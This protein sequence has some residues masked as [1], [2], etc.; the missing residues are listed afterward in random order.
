MDPLSALASAAELA[1]LATRGW[2]ALKASQPEYH[3]F[4]KSFEKELA[5]RHRD[6]PWD[7]IRARSRL[8]PEFISIALR[9]IRGERSA[10][11]DFQHYSAAFKVPSGSQ[12]DDA[13][14]ALVLAKA[15]R[16]AASEATKDYKAASRQVVGL[17]E[18][19]V[20][21]LGKEVEKQ[22]S[23]SE[24]N[25]TA[26]HEGNRELLLDIKARLDSLAP[27][28]DRNPRSELVE[29]GPNDSDA[30]A[31]GSH[32]PIHVLADPRL[33]PSGLLEMLQLDSPLDA[34]LLS[35]AYLE[36]GTDGLVDSAISLST[37]GRLTID[38]LVTAARIAAAVGRLADA[39]SLHEAAAQPETIAA[40]TRA[41]QLM[42]A[43]WAARARG[44]VQTQDRLRNSAREI[45]P[46]H[47]AVRLS[48]I[49][50]LH[51]SVAELEATE[52]FHS[53]N[54][55]DMSE[56]HAVRARAFLEQGNMESAWM[57][58]G[59]SRD[60]DPQT[61]LS[62]QV[63]ALL[64]IRRAVEAQRTD[65]PIDTDQLNEARA[66]LRE[67]QA[68]LQMQ[69]RWSDAAKVSALLAEC[70]TLAG[71][72]DGAL[73]IVSSIRTSAVDDMD[74]LAAL[75]EVAI[76]A[77]A[78]ELALRVI[79]EGDSR[80][81]TRL[82]RYDATLMVGDAESRSGALNALLEIVGSDHKENSERAAFAVLKA[83][84]E[85]V[86]IE[87]DETAAAVLQQTKP[88][89]KALLESE[90]LRITGDNA[91]A[92]RILLPL[93]TSAQPLR[94]LRDISV[95]SEAFGRALDR[96]AQ[97]LTGNHSDH[98]ELQHA[99]ILLLNDK[100][101]DAS[102]MFWQIARDDTADSQVRERALG[103]LLELTSDRRDLGAAAQ[104]IDEWRAL[105]PSSETGVWNSLILDLRS[106]RASR[107]FDTLQ[108]THLTPTSISQ[109]L[110]LA[111]V[112][113]RGGDALTAVEQIRNLSDDFGRPEELE[114]ALLVSGFKLPKDADDVPDELIE[115][116]R[117][118]V[119]AY[120]ENYPDSRFLQK[121][122]APKTP[123]E[124]AD[125]IREVGGDSHEIQAAIEE[126]INAGSVPLNAVA[127]TAPI[128]FVAKVWGR[129]L[130]LPLAN[131]DNASLGSE[132]D[133]ASNA[134]GGG[135]VWDASSIYVAG[136]L[137]EFERIR[138]VLPG[139]AVSIETTED[140]AGSVDSIVGPRPTAT[141]GIDPATGG[142]YLH[143]FTE[144]EL[145]AEEHY[146]RRMNALSGRLRSEF[147]GPVE[148]DL[149]DELKTLYLDSD[150]DTAWKTFAGS[151]LL[152]EKLERPLY[153]DD[154]A[155]RAL[156]RAR[157]IS[158]FGTLALI[159]A[160]ASAA[161]LTRGEH[162][163]I[164]RKLAERGAIGLS[165]S[166]DELIGIAE[167]SGW[168]LTSQLTNAITDPAPWRSGTP[169][170]ML[171]LLE[172]LAAAD[173]QD[174]DSFE[175]WAKRVIDAA[176]IAIPQMP[177]KWHA[178]AMLM[179]A[180]GLGEREPVLSDDTFARLARLIEED[181]WIGNP[182]GYS[183]VLSAAQELLEVLLAN[184]TLTPLEAFGVVTRR[185][186]FEYAKQFFVGPRQ[187]QYR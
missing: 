121:F 147:A 156:A 39:V 80:V 140:L 172:F 125:L 94:M 76:A 132:I 131:G 99:Q 110:I 167:E 51:D 173:S 98:D 139:S 101:E 4:W 185:I 161:L 181:P 45:D 64:S 128:G 112:Y 111:D 90:R 154:R 92:E 66:G 47:P 155:I 91:G 34:E 174:R 69:R 6:I 15:L 50:D 56:A 157:G 151:L 71:D 180:W 148:A 114:S 162:G 65:E 68:E 170:R 24:S 9:A 141:A 14:L 48:E 130:R 178:H 165:A 36:M 152:A 89:L 163:S 176:S 25:S 123:E 105:M 95:E 144:V 23:D 168:R 182:P 118:R 79:P 21:E 72:R 85:A 149:D 138:A 52:S 7:Q 142:L 187:D 55:S 42:R 58:V 44:D 143:E 1:Q 146:L 77:G 116:L 17:I 12:L 88:Q 171:E 32:T 120:T 97:L 29:H 18:G 104:V 53:E 108:T 26:L 107:A 40:Q 19:R 109:A 37:E 75:G 126:G 63:F 11:D 8:D 49:V 153:T 73:A 70:L 164:R 186:P 82:L 20:G 67:L 27:A 115:D 83:S 175:R 135:A 179:I 87:W 31:P 59:L 169:S 177:R 35:S 100:P 16:I 113:L 137:G 38:G 119:E 86:E 84:A 41:R 54:T 96:S 103:K 145:D 33:P 13:E 78:S 43:A 3:Y 122:A 60:F 106:G 28:S 46:N 150:A 159:D 2:G 136:G 184:S 57:E 74:A 166:C 124:F 160:M 134:L 102:D 30:T 158:T 10:F 127:A 93:A 129:V 133:S 5:P 183:Q 117:F 22:I 62:R 61:S 81:A